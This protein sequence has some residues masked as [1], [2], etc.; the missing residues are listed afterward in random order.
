M[1]ARV[2]QRCI[3]IAAEARG[4]PL[5]KRIGPVTMAASIPSNTSLFILRSNATEDHN[6]DS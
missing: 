2:P 5:G 1:I 3:G 4:A 6:S